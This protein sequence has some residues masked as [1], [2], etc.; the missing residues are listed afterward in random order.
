MSQAPPDEPW[1]LVEQLPVLPTLESGAPSE[2]EVP[3]VLPNAPAPNAPVPKA[4]V[5]VA[6]VPV[7]P[8]PSVPPWPVD[9]CVPPC[10]VPF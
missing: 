5:P 4:P 6:P 7:A 8:V 2:G 3:L 9:D 1:P 10:A